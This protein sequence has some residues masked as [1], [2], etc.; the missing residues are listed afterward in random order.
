MGSCYGVSDDLELTQKQVSMEWKPVED[1]TDLKVIFLIF[2]L[3]MKVVDRRITA[4][5]VEIQQLALQLYQFYQLIR[6]KIQT[7]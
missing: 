5:N 3:R 2:A 4:A 1:I 7:K 6:V